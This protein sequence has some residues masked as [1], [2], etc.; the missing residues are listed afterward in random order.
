M[1][2]T[3]RTSVELPAGEVDTASIWCDDDFEDMVFLI[4]VA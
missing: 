3:K 1:F 2:D 4:T